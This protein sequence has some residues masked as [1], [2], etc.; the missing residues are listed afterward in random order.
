MIR[1]VF[2][3][4]FIICFIGISESQAPDLL[5]EE[6]DGYY[7]Y[8]IQEDGS[9]CNREGVIKGWIHMNSVYD[10]GWTVTHRIRQRRSCKTV[11]DQG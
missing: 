7:T 2:L 8:R 11:A 10:A 5:P 6:I 4:L 3:S 9:I 1:M